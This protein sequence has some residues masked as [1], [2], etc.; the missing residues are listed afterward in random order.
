MRF[1][2]TFRELD[3]KLN[4]DFRTRNEQ[5]KV[6]FEHLQVVSDNVGVDY[7]KGDYTVTPKVEKQELATRKKFLTENVK[8]KEI[9]FF[10]VGN[11]EGG[12]TVYIGSEV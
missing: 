7:Y 6:D 8:I 11:S 5:I 9:P 3:K 1:D 12:D 10:E 2:V 4:V